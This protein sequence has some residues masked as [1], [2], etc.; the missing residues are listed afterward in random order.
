MLQLEDFN[1][2]TCLISLQSS[3]DLIL[4]LEDGES[5]H[6]HR[7]ILHIRSPVLK[8][9]LQSHDVKSYKLDGPPALLKELIKFWYSGISP[10]NLDSIAVRLLPLAAKY[11]TSGLVEMCLSTISRIL[12][13]FNVVDILIL[14]EELDIPWLFQYSLPLYK[15]NAPSLNACSKKKLKD[16][17][18]LLLKLTESCAK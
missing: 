2:E 8:S 10:E 7:C 11:E 17:P 3:A 5:I 18:D 6:A 16:Y 15:A 4:T 14:S 12:S 9:A 13:V 1:H